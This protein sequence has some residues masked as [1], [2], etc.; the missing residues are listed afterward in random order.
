[1]ADRATPE[2]PVP[3][4]QA[5]EALARVLASQTLVSAPRLR[6]LLRFLGESVLC[7]RPDDLKEYVIGCEVFGRGDSFDP[8]LDSVVRVEVRSLRIKLQRYYSGEG[9]QDPVLLDLPKGR[10]VPCFRYRAPEPP[11]TEIAAV[12]RRGVR[13]RAGLAAAGLLAAA[14]ALTG[15]LVTRAPAPASIAVLPFSSLDSDLESRLLAEGL[16]EELTVALSRVPGLQVAGR[17]SA[18]RFDPARDE[19]GAIVR[20][21]LR[22]GW[23][24]EGSLHRSGGRLRV[25]AHLTGGR[26]GRIVWSDVFEEDAAD[27]LRVRNRMAQAIAAA[28]RLPVGTAPLSRDPGPEAFDAYLRGRYLRRRMTAEGMVQSVPWFEKAVQLEP[29]FTAAHAALADSYCMMAF[30]GLAPRE[31]AAERARREA[32]TAIDLDPRDARAH[33]ALAWLAFTHDR[34]GPAAEQ[35]FRR[36]IELDPN[37]ASVREW[38]AFALAAQARFDEAVTETRKAAELEPL[39]FLT[40]NDA[41]GVLYFARRYEAA[42][43]DARR[44]LELD[45]HATQSHL[46]L[47]ACLRAQGRPAEAA[48]ELRLT[49]G[50]GAPPPEVAGRLGEACARSGNRAEALRWLKFL[51]REPPHCTEAAYIEL[52]L[53][54]PEKAL[55]LLNQACDRNEGSSLFLRVEPLAD[56]L[57]ADARFATLLRRVGL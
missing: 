22:V 54:D 10:Y 15:W 57:R 52:G 34:N 47:G 9:C 19:A 44:A 33:G 21:K 28:L 26:D 1:M 37:W 24:L 2:A 3:L 56:P 23:V 17:L 31:P 55:A 48:A 32:R 29:G 5:R 7:G 46:L 6:Q 50:P 20:R 8:R 25:A 40:S 43:Q 41:A 12:P 53:G 18:S 38:F 13:L 39:S 11:R 36:S 16:V 35:E 14:L 45:P 51:L 4:E 49:L 27:L 30:H 42:M